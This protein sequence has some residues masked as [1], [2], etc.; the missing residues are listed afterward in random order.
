MPKPFSVQIDSPKL[1]RGL[2]PSKRA[3]RDSGYLVECK[4]A[5]GYRGALQSLDAIIQTATNEI[6]DGFPFPQLFVFTNLILVCGLTGI[7]EWVS[8]LL[9]P[10]ITVAP[11]SSWCAVDFYDYIYM[12]NG[13]VAV[14]REASSNHFALEPNLPAAQAMVNV[15]GQ[16]MLGAPVEN[17]GRGSRYGSA[18]FGRSHFGG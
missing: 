16:V 2:R 10:R 9:V 13:N 12:S 14:I 15:N 5:V 7:Y 1:V 8:E 11:A 4:G 18:I 6:T 17:I 3:P